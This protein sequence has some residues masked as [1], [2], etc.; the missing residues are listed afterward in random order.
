MGMCAWARLWD[1]RCERLYLGGV[2][3]SAQGVGRAEL[4]LELAKLGV[5]HLGRYWRGTWVQIPAREQWFS[6]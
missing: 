2:L 1:W 5:Q 4:L 3:L 6:T